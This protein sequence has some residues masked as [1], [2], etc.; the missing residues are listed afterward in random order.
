MDDSN[1][2]D[3]IDAEYNLNEKSILE[4]LPKKKSSSSEKKLLYILVSIIS[5]FLILVFIFIIILLSSS[6]TPSEKEKEKENKGEKIGEINCIYDIENINTNYNL[7]GKEYNYNSSILDIFIDNEIISYSEKGYTFKKTGENEVKYIIYKPFS[8]DNMF[9]SISELISVNMTSEK[10]AKIISIN[11]AFENCNN[12]KSFNIFGFDTKEIKSLHKL[13]Y[14]TQITNVNFEN[15][16]TNNIQDFSFM[17][18]RNR[19]FFY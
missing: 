3:D 17:F 15:F 16:E 9:K 6:S 12:L 10:N 5:L 7:L 14:N 8:M 1:D 13:F 2:M 11:S 4:K 18:F 19:I